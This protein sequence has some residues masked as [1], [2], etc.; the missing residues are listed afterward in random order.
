MLLAQVLHISTHEGMIGGLVGWLRTAVRWCACV[1]LVP[2]WLD[3]ALCVR[4][5]A[6]SCSGGGKLRKSNR[7]I[8]AAFRQS[9]RVADD[10]N[11][12]ISSEEHLAY[13]PVLVD[14][15]P[16]LLSLSSFR[17]LSPHFL[18][19]LQQTAMNEAGRCVEAQCTHLWLVSGSAWTCNVSY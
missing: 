14:G 10:Q 7:S 5:L 19:I 6:L 18:H 13:I 15:L 1:V 12:G 16:S 17:R 8:A 4:R 9:S 11:D 2:K 3:A